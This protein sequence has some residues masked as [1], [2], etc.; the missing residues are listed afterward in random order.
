MGATVSTA[1]ALV[2]VEEVF[3]AA[4]VA[5][6]VISSAPSPIAVT[7]AAV[8]SYV[9]A[10]LASA[11]RLFV[12]P[13]NVNDTDESASA[14]PDNV[15][16]CSALLITLSAVASAIVG[17]LGATVSTAMALVVVEEV[18][19]AASV[20]VI[21]ISSAPSPIAVTSAAVNSYVHAPLASAVRLFVN[22]PNV[23]DTDES[24]SAVPDN[25]E[26]CSALL[27]TLSAVASA[28]VGAVGATVSTERTKDVVSETLPK[29]S[30]VDKVNV[31]APS[32]IAVMSEVV[33]V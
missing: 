32:P 23:N 27:I 26:V 33:N 25:V 18:F 11:V 1:I 30:V 6:I 29:L 24:A 10:P 14:V 31:S 5:V 2:V 9:H 17:A 4:S 20:A 8:N 19:P 28:I 16:V 15:E 7:S 21:V 13:P 12:N 3:P 22:P